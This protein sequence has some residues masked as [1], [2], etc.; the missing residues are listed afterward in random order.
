[1]PKRSR[2]YGLLPAA[3]LAIVGCAGVDPQPDYERAARYVAEVT[4]EEH[5]YLPGG[6][7]E[8]VTRKVEALLSDGLTADEAVQ[9]ALLNNPSL[10]A[11]F[12]SIGLARADVVQSSLLSNPSLTG[13]IRFPTEGGTRSLTC[14]VRAMGP[15][16]T[17]ASART[18]RA[19]QVWS[20]RVGPMRERLFRPLRRLSQRSCGTPMFR[21]FLR[22]GHVKLLH[23]RLETFPTISPTSLFSFDS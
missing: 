9:V 3:L 14:P 20:S 17:K 21:S 7:D 1:M 4:G 23:P 8:I 11:A 10:Q 13:L 22:D 6:D 18:I 19:K 15:A 16:P 5:V 12:L 2:G